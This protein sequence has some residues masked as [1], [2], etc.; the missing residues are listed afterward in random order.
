MWDLPKP[1]IE[2]VSPVG[3]QVLKHW[4]TREVLLL[5]FYTSGVYMCISVQLKEFSP[6]EKRHVTSIQSKKYT[7]KGSLCL[8]LLMG[9]FSCFL[10]ILLT[11]SCCVCY[12]VSNFFHSALCLWDPPTVLC[13]VL[14]YLL[15]DYYMNVFWSTYPFL[16]RKILRLFPIWNWYE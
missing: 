2:S 3:R 6:T 1:G 15:H 9:H 11:K 4:T 13:V 5:A 14:S 12:F 7:I 10:N 8:F 16:H